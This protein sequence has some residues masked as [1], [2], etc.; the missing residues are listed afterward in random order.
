VSTQNTALDLL[1]GLPKREAFSEEFNTLIQQAQVQGK[2]LAL[3]ILDIDVF[4]Q[5]NEQYGHAV[6]DLVLTTL[7]N[8]MREACGEQALLFRYGGDEFTLLFPNLGREQAF[9]ALE[10]L[11]VA[12]ENK[13]IDVD[14]HKELRVTISAGVAA[15]PIDGNTETELMR[16]GTQALYRAKREGSNQVLLAYDEKMVPKTTHFTETQLERL[17]ALAEELDVTEASLLREALDDLITK[18]KVNK[19][20]RS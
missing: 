20:P 16:K 11:R 4:L 18:Y 5:V 19:I 13:Q 9:L 3:G 10:R 17:S 12:M 8:M 1:T 7:V 2:P 15:Y 6:G 14:S